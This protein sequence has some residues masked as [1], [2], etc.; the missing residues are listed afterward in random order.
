MNIRY[1]ELQ[2][3]RTALVQRARS[4]AHW[5]SILAWRDRARV[6]TRVLL[7]GCCCHELSGSHWLLQLPAHVWQAFSMYPTRP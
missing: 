6:N 1:C 7:P 3:A 4:N 5:A 2:A